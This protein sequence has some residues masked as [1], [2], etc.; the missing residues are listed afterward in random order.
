V[1]PKKDHEFAL[2][3]C[4]VNLSS[5][6]CIAAAWLASRFALPSSGSF[7]ACAPWQ[8]IVERTEGGEAQ[9]TMVHTAQPSRRSLP[10]RAQVVQSYHALRIS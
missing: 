10:E 2:G 7:K 5:V 8:A 1:L 9:L 6:P 3:R 4:G